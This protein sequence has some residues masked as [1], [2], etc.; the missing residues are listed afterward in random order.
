M[1]VVTGQC[2]GQCGGRHGVV[3]SSG[4]PVAATASLQVNMDV[5]TRS[6]GRSTALGQ[7]QDE[8]QRTA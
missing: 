3:A 6:V 7:D 8:I 5:V 4:V 2:Q 1:Q